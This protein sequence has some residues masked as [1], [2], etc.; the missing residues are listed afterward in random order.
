MLVCILGVVAHIRGPLADV[1]HKD[2]ENSI[3]INCR[4]YI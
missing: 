4:K 1:Q 3:E 2:L